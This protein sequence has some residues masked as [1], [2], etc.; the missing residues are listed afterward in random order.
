[1][2]TTN[3]ARESAYDEK[4]ASRLRL[5]EAK[6]ALLKKDRE[7]VRAKA[8]RIIQGFEGKT[9]EAQRDAVLTL[10]LK[11]L[12]DVRSGLEIQVLNCQA[13][14]DIAAMEVSFYDNAP[15]LE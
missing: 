13:K 11:E 7:I 6:V 15:I 2:I 4:I 14:Y 1:M 9:N 12:E 3:D 10:F 5:M 8:D